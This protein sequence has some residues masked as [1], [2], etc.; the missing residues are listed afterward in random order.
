MPAHERL[1]GLIE[2]ISEDE[3]LGELFVRDGLPMLKLNG[4]G[5][6]EGFLLCWKTGSETEGYQKVCDFEPRKHY[7]WEEVEL[8]SGQQANVLTMLNDKKGN[9]EHLH[10]RAWHLRDDAVFGSGLD[11]VEKVFEEVDKMPRSDPLDTDLERF[12]RSQM[13][14]LLLWSILERLSA[15][16]FG[17][18]ADPTGRIM[19]LYELPGMADID[20]KRVSRSDKVSDSRDP[21]RAYRLD[22]SDAK[23]SFKYYYQVR[24]NLSHGG[25]GV[26]SD[27][28]KVHE[29]LRELLGIARDFLAQ[30]PSSDEQQ[31]R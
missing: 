10:K 8:K 18:S 13:A 24:S 23:Q 25:K 31:R 16:C 4:R 1:S 29:S 20:R 12:F 2:K 7:K 15:F 9:P 17:P 14:Y 19:Q 3:I 11:T 27:F 21:G 28:K 5:L 22:A 30:L 26:H 6:T